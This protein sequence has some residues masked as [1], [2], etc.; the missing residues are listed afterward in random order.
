[1]KEMSDGR[2]Q[3]MEL[4]NSIDNVLCRENNFLLTSHSKI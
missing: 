2:I 4:K 3:S 1:M